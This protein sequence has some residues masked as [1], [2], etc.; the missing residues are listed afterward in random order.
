[1]VLHALD[2]L[3]GQVDVELLDVVACHAS[4]LAS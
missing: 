4:M 2:E 1:V 3:H